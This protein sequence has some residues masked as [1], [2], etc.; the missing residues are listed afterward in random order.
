MFGASRVEQ[1]HRIQPGSQLNDRS[2]RQIH[3][4]AM[5][6]YHPGRSDLRGD[7]RFRPNG[8]DQQHFGRNAS[9]RNQA[10]M[11]GTYAVCCRPSRSACPVL[12]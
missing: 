2:R 7:M 12:R 8:L 5:H 4:F 3:R 10:E 1:V 9:V 6:A 11:L